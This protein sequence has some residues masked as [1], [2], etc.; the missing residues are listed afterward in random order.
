MIFKLF[1]N[2]LVFAALF[3]LTF[4]IPFL[5][6]AYNPYWIKYN[7]VNND[8]CSQVKTDFRDQAIDE[9]TSYLIHRGELKTGWQENEKIHMKEV[10]YIFDIMFLAALV[11]LV[12]LLIIRKDRMSLYKFA[13][14]N[15]VLALALFLIIPNFKSFWR[16]VFHP[17]LFNNDFWKMS[18]QDVSYY[19]TPR[20]FFKLTT[21]VVLSTWMFINV[22]IITASILF[23][24]DRSQYLN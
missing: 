8:R 5:I 13:I 15:I 17:M 18:R 23:R 9:L 2:I 22:L 10:R 20:S 4:Y 21:I 14:I 3:Y 7:C 24:K 1:K 19:I 11:S 6:T 12:A 16:E